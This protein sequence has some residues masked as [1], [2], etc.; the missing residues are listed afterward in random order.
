MF[1]REYDDDKK[2]DDYD[3]DQWHLWWDQPQG[4]IAKC[5]ACWALQD[6]F[7][8]VNGGKTLTPEHF[9]LRSKYAA[10]WS[11]ELIKLFNT[12]GD[13]VGFTKKSSNL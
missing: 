13:T 9:G 3:A 1:D 8:N 7:Y 10:T 2:D 6:L 4:I 5:H 11:K 12:A